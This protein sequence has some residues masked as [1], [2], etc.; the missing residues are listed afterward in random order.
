MPVTKQFL[1]TV[2]A[3][4][5]A[6]LQRAEN[7]IHDGLRWLQP[8]VEATVEAVNPNVAMVGS[9]WWHFPNGQAGTT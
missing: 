5:A 6:G 8:A 4:D 1:V 9:D 2:T 3:D 7:R